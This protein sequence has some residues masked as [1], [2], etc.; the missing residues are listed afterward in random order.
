MT[1]FV[2]KNILKK[3]GNERYVRAGTSVKK[4][5]TSFGQLNLKVNRVKDI[6]YNRIIKPVFKTIQFAGKQKHRSKLFLGLVQ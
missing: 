1:K 3:M 4:A 6:E 5:I 2:E